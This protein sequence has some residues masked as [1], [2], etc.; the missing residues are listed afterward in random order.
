MAHVFPQEYVVDSTGCDQI[1][2]LQRKKEQNH[3]E[4]CSAF[5]LLAQEKKLWHYKSTGNLGTLFQD[6]AS[7]LWYVK[8][9]LNKT[10][11]IYNR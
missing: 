7:V 2:S 11:I 9:P 4:K 10:S 8:V 6:S 5:V 1:Q 3:E